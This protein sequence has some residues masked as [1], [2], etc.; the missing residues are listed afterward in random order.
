[1]NGGQ[2]GAFDRQIEVRTT[3]TDRY[4][5]TLGEIF[6]GNV[7]VC[8]LMVRDGFAWRYVKYSSDRSLGAAEIEAQKARRGLWQD[9]RPVPPWEWRS[10]HFKS[11]P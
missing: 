7:S 1:M 8:L 2:N 11:A 9:P 6:T 5:R 10:S 4:G 3:G